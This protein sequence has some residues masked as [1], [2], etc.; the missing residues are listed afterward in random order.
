MYRK[1]AVELELIKSSKN[2][3]NIKQI[4]N[5][6]YMFLYFLS[7]FRLEEDIFL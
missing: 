5:V 7:I 4:I 6:R 3:T 1:G 2:R